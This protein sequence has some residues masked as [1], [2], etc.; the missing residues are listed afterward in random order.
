MKTDP[1]SIEP[2]CVAIPICSPVLSS[3]GCVRPWGDVVNGVWGGRR[4]GEGLVLVV[5]G[6]CGVSV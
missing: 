1:N 6:P 4:S 3:R 2:R 5:G